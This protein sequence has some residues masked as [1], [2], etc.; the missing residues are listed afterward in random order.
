M[1]DEKI[2]P[3]AGLQDRLA[4]TADEARPEAVAKRRARKG[5]TARENLADLI[6]GT[7]VS[8]YGQLAVAAQ[9]TRRDGDALFAET[10]ADAVITAIGPVNADLFAI[11][12]SQTALIINDYTVLAGTQGY[13]HHRKIDRLLGLA[14]EGGLPIVMYTEGGGGRPGDT[15]VLVSMAGLNVPTFHRWAALAGKVPRIAVNHGYCFAGN[16]ALFGAADLRIA[17][18]ASCIGMAGPAMIEGGGLGSWKPQ[19]IGPVSVHRKN[20][21]VDIVVADEAEATAMA[22]RVLACVQGPLSDWQSY[23]QT[24]LPAL[25]PTNRRYAFDTRKILHHLFDI[26]SLIETRPDMGRAIVTGLARIEGRAVAVLASDCRHLGGAIDGESAI[27]AT[28]LYQLAERWRLPVV[29]FIDTPGFMVG[30]ESEA[31]GAPRLMSDLFIAGAALTQPIVAVFLRRAYGLG[32]MA[33][34]GGSFEVPRYAVSWPQGEFGAMG[35]E[36]A[37]HLGFRQELAEAPDDTAR[38]ALF[39]SLLADMYDKGRATE[40]ASYLE[41]DAVIQP[42]ETRAAITSALIGG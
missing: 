21:V 35:L 25:M 23:D 10:A 32:A 27:K 30:P 4:K 5:R 22:K 14:A 37:V 15:D 8:E 26:G 13:F 42:E 20:G 33:M 1:S 11:A 34:T 36:G 28:A 3:Y 38:Q 2:D 17:T 19:D 9:R 41:I 40:A 16:A 6:D 31:E 7:A 39:E 12:D 29:S 18:E 24:E